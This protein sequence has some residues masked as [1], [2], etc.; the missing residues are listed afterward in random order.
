MDESLWCHVGWR[1]DAGIFELDL[2]ACSKPKIPNFSFSFANKDI[3][4][5][6]VSVHDAH[7]LEVE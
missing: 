5:F 1:A 7:G 3:G 6:D 2:R 4:S